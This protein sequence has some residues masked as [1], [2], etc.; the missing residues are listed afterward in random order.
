MYE[1]FYGLGAD[2]FSPNPDPSYYLA[3]K[4]HWRTRAYLEYG[5]SRD[6]GFIVITGEIGAALFD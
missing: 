5:A 4:Q 2:P 3:G 6:E 1:A